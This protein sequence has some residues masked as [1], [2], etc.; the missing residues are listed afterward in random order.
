MQ[1]QTVNE[2][3]AIKFP[4]MIMRLKTLSLTSPTTAS[5]EKTNSTTSNLIGPGRVLGNF[6]S[7]A[8]KRLERALGDI[9]HKAGFGLEAIY[10]K[11]LNLCL[12]D[13]RTN[14]EKGKTILSMRNDR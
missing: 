8:G 6:Y 10:Q 12:E 3:N 9:A 5:K 7:S 4:A 1:C 2:D 13:W 11:I 14:N